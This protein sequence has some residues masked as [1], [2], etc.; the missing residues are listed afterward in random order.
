MTWQCSWRIEGKIHPQCKEWIV[1][2]RKSNRFRR[3]REK[4]LIQVYKSTGKEISEWAN[5]RARWCRC[6]NSLKNR[7]GD[8]CVSQRTSNL[9][10]KHQNHSLILAIGV[11]GRDTSHWETDQDHPPN[12]LATTKLTQPDLKL[13]LA[14]HTVQVDNTS[15]L[16]TDLLAKVGARVLGNKSEMTVAMALIKSHIVN[17]L[18][19]MIILRGAIRVIMTS[20]TKWET[21]IVLL[22]YQKVTR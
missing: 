20:K 21:L 13:A 7:L 18:L 22:L 2:L 11:V 9:I 10:T 1:Q 14:T 8:A 6:R 5:T 12:P 4:H 15:R 19:I 16:E 3:T 17:Q